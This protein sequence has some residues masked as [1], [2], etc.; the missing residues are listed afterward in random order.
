MLTKKWKRQKTLIALACYLIISCSLLPSTAVKKYTFEDGT[1]ESFWIPEATFDYSISIA[2]NPLEEGKSARFEWRKSDWNG[3]RNTKGTELKSRPFPKLK[4][5]TI[6]FRVYMDEDLAPPS[7]K[8]L[9]IMQYHS[10][11]DFKAGEY[12]RKPATS[13]VYQDGKMKYT[14]RSSS[15]LVTPSVDGKPQYDSEGEIELPPPINRAWNTFKI[16]QQFDFSG[17]TG[18]IRVE[19]NKKAY[20]VK[21]IS[22]GFNDAQGPFVKYGIYCP[23][24][25]TNERVVLFFDD[26]SLETSE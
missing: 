22:L 24:S 1:W 16:T 6:S 2:K 14:Y 21:N 20:S 17:K 3:S 26:I 8:P 10:M 4:H 5:Q 15:E 7:S 18:M 23:Q 19:M 12:W 11:P 9:I 25:Y 13:L